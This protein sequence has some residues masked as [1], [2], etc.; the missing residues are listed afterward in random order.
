MRFRPSISLSRR[1]D[2]HDARRHARAAAALAASPLLILFVGAAI[3]VLADCA[4]FGLPFTDL[5]AES[6]F[7]AAIAEAYYT[8]LTNGTSATTY[9]PSAT[10]TRDQMAAFITRTLDQSLLRGSPRATRG[11]WWK[12][13]PDYGTGLA[14]TSANSPVYARSDGTDV[15]VATD[16]GV[17]RVR[18]SDGKSLQTWDIA[19]GAS[20]LVIALG[21]VFATQKSSGDIWMIDEAKA[22]GDVNAFFDVLIGSPNHDASGIAFDGARL[23]TTNGPE[24]ISIF[25][26]ESSGTIWD[27]SLPAS[28]F[29][30]PFGIFFD[31]ANIWVTDTSADE[32]KG[33]L[34]KLDSTGK[35]LQTITVGRPLGY[36]VFDGRNIWVPSSVDDSLTVVR[37]SDGKVLKTFSAANG[38]AN[39]LDTPVAAAFDGQRILVTNDSSGGLGAGLSL[40]RATDLSAIGNWTLNG[41]AGP[42]G[43]CSDGANFWVTFPLSNEIGRF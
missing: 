17:E 8:G 30:E 27:S 42:G 3:R 18:A 10:V 9:A 7:C 1:G 40:F 25:T 22:P 26:P 36:P 33:L 34:L 31:G 35:I 32:S 4:S 13:P 23:W 28:S 12:Q 29:N 16:D 15:W 11:Q 37:A 21:K 19:N 20:A 43:A 39:G 5:G 6:G 24:G 41:V 38:N 2:P 14:L